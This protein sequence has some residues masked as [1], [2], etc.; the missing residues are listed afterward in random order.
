[1]KA[2]RRRSLSVYCERIHSCVNELRTSG[3]LCASTLCI[4]CTFHPLLPRPRIAVIAKQTTEENL[5]SKDFVLEQ[6]ARVNVTQRSSVAF[7]PP[8]R[9]DDSSTLIFELCVCFESSRDQK[10]E[11]TQSYFNP[12]TP[13]VFLKTIGLSLKIIPCSCLGSVS[14]HRYSTLFFFRSFS[15]THW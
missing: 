1:M 8:N 5:S 2:I 9:K 15:H 14:T 4:P 7:Y 11:T 3:I 12:G 13:S 10:H 6:A